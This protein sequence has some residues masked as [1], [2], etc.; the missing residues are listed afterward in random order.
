MIKRFRSKVVEIE[1]VQLCWKNWQ[2][3]CDF[4]GDI[5]NESN[6]GRYSPK[7]SD[8]CNE[9][10]SVMDGGWIELTIPTLEGPMIANHGDWIVK[11]LK[12]EFYPV[13]PDIFAM[14]YEEVN[15]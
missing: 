13:K 8:T 4:L 7:V 2:F 14:K 1:A 9:C 5:I 11:G 12:G 3:V 15:G 6:P 10:P